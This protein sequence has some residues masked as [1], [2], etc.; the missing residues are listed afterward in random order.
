LF[1]FKVDNEAAGTLKN[2]IGSYVSAETLEKFFYVT[3]L[4]RLKSLR[5]IKKDIQ[6]SQIS[7]ETTATVCLLV[8]TI[9]PP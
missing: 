8:T 7:I 2:M 9:A 1:V 3:G 6:I 4:K 5:V